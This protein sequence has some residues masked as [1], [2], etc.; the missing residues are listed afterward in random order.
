LLYKQGGFINCSCACH[1]YVWGCD[2]GFH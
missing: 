2:F 1:V